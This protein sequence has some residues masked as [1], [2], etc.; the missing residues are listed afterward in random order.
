MLIGC[1]FGQTCVTPFCIRVTGLPWPSEELAK[2]GYLVNKAFINVLKYLSIG[3]PRK[4][5]Y[6]I[7]IIILLAFDNKHF[8][9]VTFV[10]KSL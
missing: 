5:P 4:T 8:T 2:Q 10:I 6:K 3:Q 1:V 7:N 9:K